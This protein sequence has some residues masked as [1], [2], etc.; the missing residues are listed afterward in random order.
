MS[1]K[2]R[3]VR[4]PR[5]CP[6]CGSAC[7]ASYLYGM[8]AVDEKLERELDAGRIVLGG[9]CVSEDDPQWQCADCGQDIYHMP[10]S[11]R[12]PEGES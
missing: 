9:C 4:K 7:I 1:E 6:K 3:A 5:K 12:Y 8:P 10:E 2:F 11:A